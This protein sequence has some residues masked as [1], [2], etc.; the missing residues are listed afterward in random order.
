M[1]STCLSTYSSTIVEKLSIVK[2]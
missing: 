2:T 1:H